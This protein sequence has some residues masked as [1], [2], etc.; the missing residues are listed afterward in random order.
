MHLRQ[1]RHSIDSLFTFL[2]LIVFSMFTL[3]LA[4]TGAAV[5]KNSAA[6]LEENYTSRTAVAYV[7]EKIRQHDLSD[8]IWLTD[9]EQH[10]ALALRT[11]AEEAEFITYI[12]FYD[13]FL[14]ELFIRAESEPSAALGSRLVELS[15]F[16]IRESEPQLFCITAVSPEGNE[17]S[18]TVHLQAGSSG[19][20]G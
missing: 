6:H 8:S 1:K 17:L 4:G 10:P 20:A 5:Y 14:C 16:E 19:S 18:M 15:S 2:L 3:I 11:T 13:G 7:A 12:Y 9:V